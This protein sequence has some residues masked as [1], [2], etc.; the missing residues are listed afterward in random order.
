MASADAFPDST[1]AAHVSRV[2]PVVDP[3][4]GTVEVRFAVP[5]PPTY[6]RVDMT[7]SVNVETERR[8]AALVVPSE[9]DRR[10]SARPVHGSCSRVTVARSVRPVQPGARG[11]TRRGDPRGCDR[12]RPRA[13][14]RDPSRDVA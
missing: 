14:R 1:F 12:G 4:Q 11:D 8:T 5:Q 7:I 10:Q 3:A 6:L 9:R 2:A 13:A